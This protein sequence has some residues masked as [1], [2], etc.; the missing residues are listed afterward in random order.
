MCPNTELFLVPIFLYLDWIQGNTDQKKLRIWTF[1]TQWRYHSSSSFSQTLIHP[2]N[3]LFV[4]CIS[5]EHK[6]W[7]MPNI[8]T[9]NITLLSLILRCLWWILIV[10]MLQVPKQPKFSQKYSSFRKYLQYRKPFLVQTFIKFKGLQILP[11]IN[12]CR[13]T[14]KYMNFLAFSKRQNQLLCICDWNRW[15]LLKF[16]FLTNIFRNFSP[17]VQ[18]NYDEEQHFAVHLFARASLD[19]CFWNIFLFLV[20]NIFQSSSVSLLLHLRSIR[21]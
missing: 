16:I 18:N 13:F 21:N 17:R 6:E 19:D 15:T 7:N 14:N 3:K 2:P 8:Q 4:A 9:L 10:V 5:E 12:D 20:A 1:F 11:I